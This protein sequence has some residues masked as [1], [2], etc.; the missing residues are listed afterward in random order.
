MNIKILLVLS[1]IFSLFTGIGYSDIHYVR[2]NSPAPSFPYT[3]WNTAARSIQSA[4]DAASD[5]D[6]VLVTNGVYDTDCTP[7]PGGSTSNRVCVTNSLTLR[8]VNGSDYTFI[9]GHKHSGDQYGL[10]VSAVRGVYMG[11]A[12]TITGFTIT[13]GHSNLGC[14]GGGLKASDTNCV[15]RDCCFV[16]NAA[17]VSGGAV[18][19]ATAFNCSF[20]DNN[21]YY[22]S[23]DGGAAAD[24]VLKEC[25]FSNNDASAEGG[26]AYHC[27]LKKCILCSNN[28]G[29]HGGGAS[30]SVL[31]NCLIYNNSSGFGTAAF[32]CILENCTACCNKGS[33][34]GYDGNATR[35]GTNINCIIYYNTN[36]VGCIANI[37]GGDVTYTCSTNF[38]GGTGCITNNPLF[39]DSANY[40]FRLQK[41]SVCVDAGNTNTSYN[42]DILNYKHCDSNHDG[43]KEPDMGCYEVRCAS[44]FIIRSY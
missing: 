43:I 13:N 44:A 20:R 12:S 28:S 31:K 38:N 17:R 39:M 5:N 33:V 7:T 15:I 23:A 32:N 42:S 27:I 30:R 3:S 37:H 18:I 16:N 9:K 21:V 4:L 26:A 25:V 34:P 2:A 40:D 6:T 29:T 10:G 1:F 8:S 14:S 35:N 11:N 22:S 19:N 41:N 36:A 24:A